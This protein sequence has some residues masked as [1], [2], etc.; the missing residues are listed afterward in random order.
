MVSEVSLKERV[1]YGG[2]FAGQNFLLII[3]LN[4][5]MLYYTDFV[6]LK[7]LSIG[8]LFLIARIWDAI[9]DPIM[10]IIVDKVNFKSG[11]KFKPWI[12]I[13]IYLLPLGTILLFTNPF[14][15]PESKLVW[16]YIT[17]ILWG[18]IYTISDIPIF[19]LATVMTKFNNERV[20]IIAIG[21]LFAGIG[22]LCGAILL[23]PLKVKLGWSKSIVIIALIALVV[24]MPVKYLTRERLKY[25]RGK[26]SI[27]ELIKAVVNNKYLLL[28]YLVFIL[29]NITNSSSTTMVYFVTYNL[30]NELLIPLLSLAA[31][32][33]FI[34]LPILLPSLVIRYGKRKIFISLMSISVVSSILFYYVGYSNIVVVFIFICF[35][36]IALNLPVIMMAMFTTD[37]LEYAYITT[38]KRFEGVV[39]SVQ[40]FSIK[41]TL[42]LQGVIGAF[43]LSRSGYMP[44]IPQSS[45]T[46]KEIW[47]M[48]TIYPTLGQILAILVFINFYKL[49]EEDVGKVTKNVL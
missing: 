30:G 12:N 8:I 2:Y 36:Y 5:L 26:N 10:G 1:A 21:R 38:G 29:T 3:I 22:A 41:I 33:S 7:P 14:E 16:A 37:C 15:D 18:M 48:N 20:K 28:I 35:K 9:N 39:F 24:M 6:G 11:L 45:S 47:R 46:L 44:N 25:P 23:T 40:T 32:S 17:Y 31:A 19:A 13:V 42:A 34:I 49:R 27:L 4:F 43:T